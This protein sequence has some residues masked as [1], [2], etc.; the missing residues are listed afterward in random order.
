MLTGAVHRVADCM[1]RRVIPQPPEWQHIGNQI[2][3][4][5]IFARA[6]FVGVNHRQPSITLDL[7]IIDGHC[8]RVR[9]DIDIDCNMH[10]LA[11]RKLVLWTLT[12][13]VQPVD[14][15]YVKHPAL[16]RDVLKAHLCTARIMIVN[17]CG[18]AFAV[19]T[20]GKKMHLSTRADEVVDC[21]M[22]RRALWTDYGDFVATATVR[23]E[24]IVS[25]RDE[26]E[27]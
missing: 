20:P 24:R 27:Q 26:C 22:N 25:A 15:V 11:N 8:G 21:A 10:G 13:K 5:M 4:A 3:A 9:A 2:N 17:T 7:K 18:Y 19:D 14:E 23:V 6:D 12:D 1:I 16:D